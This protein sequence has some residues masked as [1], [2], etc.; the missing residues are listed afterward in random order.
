M[1]SA[2]ARAKRKR[3]Q[4]A[5]VRGRLWSVVDLALVTL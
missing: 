5:I 3:E 1:R 2:P 4:I